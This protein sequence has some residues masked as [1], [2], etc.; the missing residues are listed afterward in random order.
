MLL[1]VLRAPL[2]FHRPCV[3]VVVVR[4]ILSLIHSWL[5]ASCGMKLCVNGYKKSFLTSEVQM[6]RIVTA[7]N[8]FSIFKIM[9]G[10]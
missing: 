9:D 3:H 2:A 4:S 10:G 5:R 7:K 1:L 8:K 6:R